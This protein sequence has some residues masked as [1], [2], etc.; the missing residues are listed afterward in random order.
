MNTLTGTRARATLA[1]AIVGQTLVLLDNTI[2]NIAADIL[3]DPVRGIGASSTEL[4]WSISAYSLMFAALTL[5][6]GALT[7]RFGPQA[8]LVTGLTVL[9]LASVAAALATAPVVLIAARGVM[10]AGGGLVTPATLALAT[11]GVRPGF[12]A[13]AIAIWSSAGGVAVAI[14]PVLGGF[15]LARFSWG[16]VF[17]VNVPIAAACALA[18][19]FLVPKLST[20]DRRPLD[21]GGMALSALGLGALVYGIIE[22]GGTAGPAAPG[23]LLPLLGGVL[24]LA[25][26]AWHQK[27]SARPSFDVTLFTRR[28]FAGGTLGLLLAFAGL[29][30]QLFYCAFYLQGVRRLSA[31]QA[32]FVMLSAAAGIVLGTQLCTRVVT[33][34]GLRVTVLLGLLTAT[35]TFAV[36][37]V[38]DATTPLAWMVVVLFA[39]GAGTGL[40]FAPVTA[41]LVATLPPG[42]TGAGSAI[43]TLTRPLGSTIG[44]AALGTVLSAE[45]RTAI[46][47]AVSGLPAE[48]ATRA[49]GSAEGARSLGRQDLVAAADD[50][51]LHAMHVTATWTAAVSLAGC[52]VILGCFRPER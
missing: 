49:T 43:A 11:L 10:G 34:I 7:D 24:A 39:Q 2:L 29:A 48:L 4:A 19:L 5:T 51:Y 12:R 15:L 28:R 33:A 31:E 32:G 44:V 17:L 21:P 18:A 14:G 23:A 41:E 45:Y 42:R 25:V 40:V 37:V 1:V 47:P 35:A 50:A 8:V 46:T 27:R 6:G 52:L 30:G 16:A 38:F 20:S 26:F 22:A 13:R 3:S 36:Y 9:A